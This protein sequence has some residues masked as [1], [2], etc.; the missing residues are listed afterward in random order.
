MAPSTTDRCLIVV[1]QILVTFI[2][3]WMSPV[4]R[5]IILNHFK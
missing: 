2:I 1:R 3:W 4:L 5:A